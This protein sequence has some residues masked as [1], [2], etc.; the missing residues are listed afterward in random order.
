MAQVAIADGDDAL[1]AGA[2]LELGRR[3]LAEGDHVAALASLRQGAERAA[4]LGE[5]VLGHALAELAVGLTAVGEHDL[6]DRTMVSA[7]AHLRRAG[8]LPG[9]ADVALKRARALAVAGTTSPRIEGAWA[10]ASRRCAM[11]GLDALELE[12]GLAATRLACARDDTAL[13]LGWLHKLVPRLADRD[14]ADAIWAR[15]ELRARLARVR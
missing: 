3:Q 15:D 14:D 2:L 5:G 1:A 12:A 8:D 6:A 7:L 13:A 11:A 9:S 10:D 4:L